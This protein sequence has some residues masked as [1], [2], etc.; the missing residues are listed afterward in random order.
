MRNCL[1]KK[2]RILRYI[3]A[4]FPDLAFCLIRNPLTC[5]WKNQ[6]GNTVNDKDQD[7][8]GIDDTT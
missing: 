3:T 2:E 8:R 6:R 5:I 4:S 1:R 7:Q